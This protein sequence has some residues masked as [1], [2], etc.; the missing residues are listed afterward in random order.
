M[1]GKERFKFVNA[2][3]SIAL[4]KG[5]MSKKTKR[6]KQIEKLLRED[7]VTET[8]DFQTKFKLKL[9]H[10]IAQLKSGQSNRNK[11]VQEF[12]QRPL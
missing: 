4:T 6:D 3:S 1:L 11:T 2:V 5:L 12:D 7:T 10:K 8:E 9:S